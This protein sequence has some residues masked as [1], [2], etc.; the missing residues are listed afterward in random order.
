MSNVRRHHMNLRLLLVA[1]A[2][3]AC[4]LLMPTAFLGTV[5]GLHGLSQALLAPSSSEFWGFDLAYSLL[6]LGGILG[7]IAFLVAEIAP[8]RLLHACNPVRL[9]VLL[10]LAWGSLAALALGLLLTLT[11]LFERPSMYSFLGPAFLG[12]S[13]VGYWSWRRVRRDA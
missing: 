8:Q 10:G 9:V 12:L 11:T 4:V 7:F 3:I 2:V 5:I 13:A 1:S 6:G